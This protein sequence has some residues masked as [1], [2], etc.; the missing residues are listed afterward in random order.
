MNVIDIDLQGHFDHFN[1][2]FY[3][4]RLVRAITHHKF[5]LESPNLQQTC[6]LAYF[7]LVLKIEVIDFDLQGHFDHFDLEF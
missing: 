7:Q 1:S 4:I 6:I 5:V 3:E 2:E